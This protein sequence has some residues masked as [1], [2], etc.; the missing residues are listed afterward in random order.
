[1]LYYPVINL[2]RL[3][4]GHLCIGFSPNFHYVQFGGVVAAQVFYFMIQIT[5][6]GYNT[7]RH[8]IMSPILDFIYSFYLVILIGIGMVYK[9]D[10]YEIT[11]NL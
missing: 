4:F 1:M 6:S 10:H 2:G 3:I 5:C 8:K 9:V 11:I 7:I